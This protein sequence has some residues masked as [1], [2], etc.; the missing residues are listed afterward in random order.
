[1]DENGLSDNQRDG[2][3]SWAQMIRRVDEDHAVGLLTKIVVN[4]ADVAPSC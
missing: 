4:V 2:I 3:R 1:M